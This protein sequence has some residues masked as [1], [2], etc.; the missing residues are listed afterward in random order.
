MMP[1][2]YRSR[3]VGAFEPVCGMLNVGRAEPAKAAVHAVMMVTVGVCAVY[4]A[5]AWL[6]RRQ[7]HLAFNAVIY[8]AAFCWERS[9]V[10][11]HLAACTPEPVPGSRNAASRRPRTDARSRDAA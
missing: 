11:H 2:S 10:M 1:G 5:T 7:R 9:H 6:K 8:A 4:N 3:A